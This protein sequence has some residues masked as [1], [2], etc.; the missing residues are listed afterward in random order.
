MLNDEDI[1]VQVPMNRAAFLLSCC[2]QTLYRMH[3]DNQIV[4]NKMRGRTMV[5]MSEIIRIKNGEPMPGTVEG[6]VEGPQKRIVKKIKLYPR[7]TQ[8]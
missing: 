6:P 4:L 8:N 3:A 1:P 5:P 2:R 7:V